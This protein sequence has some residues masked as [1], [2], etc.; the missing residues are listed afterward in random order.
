MAQCEIRRDLSKVEDNTRGKSE[1][2]D[3]GTCCREVV[4]EAGTNCLHDCNSR[5]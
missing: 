5:E 3:D 2:N 4:T 1:A